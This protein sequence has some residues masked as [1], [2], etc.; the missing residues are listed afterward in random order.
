LLAPLVLG[1]QQDPFKRGQAVYVLAARDSRLFTMCPTTATVRFPDGKTWKADGTALVNY[2]LE[3]R[4]TVVLFGDRQTINLSLPLPVAGAGE[5]MAVERTVPGR[6]EL[7]RVATDPELK[8]RIEKEFLKRKE[9]VIVDSPTKADFVFVAEGTYLPMQIGKTP[10]QNG[11]AFRPLG[12]F[13]ADF[14]QS[15]FAVVVPASVFD[16]GAIRSPALMAARL[17]EG[18][19]VWQNIP[20]AGGREIDPAS[21]ESVVAQFHNNQ[22]RPPSHFPLCA[23]SAENLRIA[24]APSTS[25]AGA[26]D[27]NTNPVPPPMSAALEPKPAGAS[28]AIK[29]D[30]ALVTVPVTVTD[31]DEKHITDLKYSDFHVFEDDR[32]QKI[33]RIIPEAEPFDVALMIDTSA[34]MRSKAEEIQGVALAFAGAARPED[35]LMVVS[36]DNR[37]FVH[38]ELTSDRLMLRGAI[39][40]MRPGEGTRLYDAVDLVLADRLDKDQGRKAIV[41]FADGVDTRSRI[42]GS[43][44]TLSAIEESNVLVYGIQYDT[45]RKDPLGQL[46]NAASWVVLPEDIRNN[47]ER[48]ARADKYLYELCNGSGGELYVAP[49]GGNLSEVF[50]RIA[51][52]LRHQLTLCYYRSSAK[53]DGAFHRLRVQVDRPGVKVRSRT[54]YRATAPQPPGK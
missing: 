42:A 27:L 22:K 23:A 16:P 31:A 29:V 26:P 38:S 47:S 4:E 8:R 24:G 30:V 39:S 20:I 46:T 13:K 18:S 41:L 44:D 7:D 32:E 21:P 28:H 54:G 53:Q 15:V 36:F 50:A 51:D 11:L 1:F 35:R 52:Q 43:A 45:Y 25:R 14:L 19:A 3:D 6:A 34:S 49:A 17:W 2:Y 40:L 9:Y 37:I 10:S 5:K 33:D 12:D 48:Y